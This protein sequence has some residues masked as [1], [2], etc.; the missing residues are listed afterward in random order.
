M[1]WRTVAETSGAR[2]GRNPERR[3]TVR[4]T[5]PPPLE[6]DHALFL[7]ID[8]T[9]LDLAPTP[10]RVRVDARIAALL[11]ALAR[12]LGG[13]VALIT[14]RTLEDAGRLFPELSLPVAGQHG[15]ERRAADGSIHLHD[16]PSSGLRSL[17]P[18]LARFAA[19]HEGL[20]LED[21]GTTLALHYRLAPLLASHVHQTLKTQLAAAGVGRG[22]R[23][24]PGKGVLE[25]KP[26][27]R[28]K[29]T[30]ILEYMA[31]PPFAG[32]FPVFVG[33][34][35]TDEYGF[36]AVLRVGGWAVKVGPG[37]TRA[38]FRLPNVGAVRS[39]LAMAVPDTSS[40]AD[41]ANN[42]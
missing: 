31:E 22:L 12:R 17:Y 28:D 6:R 19:R 32:R 21:K 7:D 15:L 41:S 18:Q 25:I 16:A 9:L 27:G 40:M 37:R 38:Q 34:D 5:A 2:S 8:G 24:Q 36:A 4:R 11:P 39:W 30:A 14:G 42:A 23:L 3:P 35:Q 1:R 26:D 33:D 20:W 10:D 29:G 13:A